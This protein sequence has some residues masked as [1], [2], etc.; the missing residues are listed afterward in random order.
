MERKLKTKELKLERT[1]R[2]KEI[3]Y[4]KNSMKKIKNFKTIQ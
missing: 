2:D 3:T 4:K 1:Y